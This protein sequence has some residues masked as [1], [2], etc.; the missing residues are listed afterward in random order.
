MIGQKA[1][2]TE[3]SE[4]RIF[5][6][7][8]KF[9]FMFLLWGW[10][11]RGTGCSESLWN[12]HSWSFS[13]FS[14]PSP[15]TTWFN[16]MLYNLNYSMILYTNKQR[17]VYIYTCTKPHTLYLYIYLTYI[18]I[19]ERFD[20]SWCVAVGMS[21]SLELFLGLPSI[22]QGFEEPCVTYFFDVVTGF[23]ISTTNSWPS[24]CISSTSC[25]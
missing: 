22:S 19:F 13:E 1:V 5:I 7:F 11:Y 12:L 15:W 21:E 6:F 23:I 24:L 18:Y 4:W 25:S 17:C 3:I 10:W 2:N 14:W 8:F 16:W 9:I 20:N